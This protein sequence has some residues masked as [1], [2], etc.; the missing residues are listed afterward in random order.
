MNFRDTLG[1][2]FSYGWPSSIH[3]PRQPAADTVQM[4][5]LYLHVY[6]VLFFPP[7]ELCLSGVLLECVL[8]RSIVRL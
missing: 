8:M 6:D 7:R 1:V 2:S 3:P 5:K 4:E